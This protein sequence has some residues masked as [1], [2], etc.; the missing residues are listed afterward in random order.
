M[1]ASYRLRLLLTVIGSDIDDVLR[2]SCLSR[3]ERICAPIAVVKRKR[4]RGY[5]AI[6]FTRVFTRD[7]AVEV[8]VLIVVT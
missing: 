3:K 1:I 2:F 7:T 4:E 5:Y 8:P 6:F